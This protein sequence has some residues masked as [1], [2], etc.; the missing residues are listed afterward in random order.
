MLYSTSNIRNVGT[1]K[2]YARLSNKTRV[3]PMQSVRELSFGYGMAQGAS[4]D[5]ASTSLSNAVIARRLRAK[6]T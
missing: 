2:F 5:I 1:A 3:A 6:E 4:I